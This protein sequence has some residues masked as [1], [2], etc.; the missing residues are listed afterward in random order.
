MKGAAMVTR[1]RAAFDQRVVVLTEG[2]SWVASPA[3]GVERRMLDRIGDEVARATSI[4][5]YAPNAC[6]PEHVHGGGEE[7]FVLEGLFIDDDGEYPAGTYVRN[8]AGSSHAPRAGKEGATLFLKLHQFAANDLARVVVQTTTAPWLPG[9]A[10]GLSVLALHD[11]GT[12]HT[13]LVRWAPNTQFHRHGHWGGEEIFVLDGVFRDEH[14]HYPAGSWLRSPHMSTH[15]PFTDSEGATIFVKVGHL[16]PKPG[17][18]N[19][20]L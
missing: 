20:W 16:S 4:V 12:E 6:F 13:A 1:I 9:G 19:A 5:R 17:L 7:L 2:E 10:A 14:G 18:A 3:A 8:P 11:F 15:T